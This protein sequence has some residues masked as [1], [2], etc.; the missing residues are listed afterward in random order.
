MG[1]RGV[2]GGCVEIVPERRAERVLVA[3]L[4]L[5]VL[6]DGRPIVG[7]RQQLDQRGEFRLDLLTSKLCARRQRP[8]AAFLGAGLPGFVPKNEDDLAEYCQ[9]V[10]DAYRKAEDIAEVLAA[11]ELPDDPA[12]KYLQ[13]LGDAEA[14]KESEYV[15]LIEQI[16]S[17]AGADEGDDE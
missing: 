5:H 2:F 17:K 16:I 1:G 8:Q 7:R 3:G 4:D 10:K 6:D 15:P 14:F 13:C 11:T 9:Q 12:L